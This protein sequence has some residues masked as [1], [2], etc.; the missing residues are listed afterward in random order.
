MRLWFAGLTM[1]GLLLLGMGCGGSSGQNGWSY[2][3]R[4]DVLEIAYGSG[5]RFPQYAALHTDSSYL[6][7]IYGPGS[8]WGTSAVL[9]PSLWTGGAYYQG[10]RITLEN[11]R[12]EGGVLVIRFWGNIAGLR[13]AGIVRL[14]PP[15]R[16]VLRATVTITSVTG[17]VPLD[18]R[19]GERFKPVMLSSMHISAT[20]WDTREAYVGAQ[21]YPLPLNGWILQPPVSGRL[22][23]L[24]GGSS[25][26]KTNAPTLEVVFDRDLP[27][28]GWVTASD[29][30]N[31]DNVGFWCGADTILRSW[32]YALTAS[33]P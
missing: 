17:D 20:Q 21:R 24:R 23:G 19:P 31:D 22:F 16:N 8:G 13:V 29:D 26:W 9:L 6:R 2:R 12:V 33:A 10:A 3:Q 15:A 18:N 30:P 25:A 1:A 28:T 11:I 7:L 5:T 27:I 32:N 4:G 14:L